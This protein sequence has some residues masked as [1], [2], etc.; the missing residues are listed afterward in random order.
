MTESHIC[1][2]SASAVHAYDYGHAASYEPY[3]LFLKRCV[4]LQKQK[5]VISMPY[6]IN[7]VD[8]DDDVIRIE[9]QLVVFL[10]LVV[11]QGSCA[12]ALVLPALYV[13]GVRTRVQPSTSVHCT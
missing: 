6:L 11:I 4:T 12:L 5:G 7:L 13:C 9:R 8:M 3:T 10:C 2:N 1:R